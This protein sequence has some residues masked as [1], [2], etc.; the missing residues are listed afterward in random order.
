MDEPSSALDPIAEYN[1]N[2]GIDKNAKGK[3][4]V[5]IPTDYLPQ[6]TLTGFICLKRARLLK[7]VPTRSLSAV[8]ENTARCLSYRRK[9]IG[10]N[11][12]ATKQL[13]NCSMLGGIF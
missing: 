8:A 13:L 5:F 4:V 2:V 12:T 6:D 3:T 9:N 1:L 7:A 11:K 10:H